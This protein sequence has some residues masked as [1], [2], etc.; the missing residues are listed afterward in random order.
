MENAKL[1]TERAMSGVSQGAGFNEIPRFSYI[2]SKFE[3]DC[4]NYTMRCSRE[5][6]Y[7][8]LDA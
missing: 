5:L 1:D 7:I 8:V 6:D 2:R 3:L 4:L